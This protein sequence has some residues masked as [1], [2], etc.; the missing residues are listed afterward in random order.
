ME[1]NE[2]KGGT[3]ALSSLALYIRLGTPTIGR[4]VMELKILF[5]QFI[6]SSIS[7]DGIQRIETHEY[8]YDAIREILLNALK[9]AD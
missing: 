9:D 6:S 4:E 1:T 3:N 2:F 8:P 7:Y 5:S